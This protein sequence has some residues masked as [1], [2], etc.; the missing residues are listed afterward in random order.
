[1]TGSP[2]AMQ[3]R[4]VGVSPPEEQR[5]RAHL[6]RALEQVFPVRFEGREFGAWRELDAV[7]SLE[8]GG[9]EPEL[10]RGLRSFA[11]SWGSV[12][13]D[14][15]GTVGIGSS[16][17]VDARL[18]TRSLCDAR[19][20]ALAGLPPERSTVLAACGDN[21][22]WTRRDAMDRV[23]LA[24]E[25]A[26]GQSIRDALAPGRWLSLL[27]LV[28]YLRDVAGDLAWES[29]PTRA[30]FMI[31]DPNLHWPSYGYVR[32]AELAKHA[33]ADGYHVAVATI[34]LDAWLVHPGVARVFR[35]N[36]RSLSLLVHGNDHVREEL[37]RP[38]SKREALSLL[39][40]AVRR[41]TALQL[42][43]G[44]AIDRLM[45]AP[46]GVCSEEM[47]RT[48]LLVGFEGLCYSWST[49]R[50]SDQPL[51][52]WEPSELRAGLPVFPRFLVTKPRD[53]IVLRSF[54]GQPLILY[55]HHSDLANG[56]DLFG[57]AAAFV[58]REPGVQWGGAERIARSSYLTRRE[59]KALTVRLCAR[60]VELQIPPG[61]E[62]LMVELPS[63]HS[64]PQQ[65]MVTFRTGSST[66]L[67]GFSGLLAGPFP[68]ADAG[69]AE[70]Y[71]THIDAVDPDDIRPP[72][73]RLHPIL[74]RVA[75]ESR[76]RLTPLAKPIR[77][78]EK[79]GPTP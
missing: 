23:A 14:A 64:A 66:T 28:H 29:P 74:R 21:A 69:S 16:P 45:V 54:L 25:L 56:L 17:L 6:F 33:E 70:I 3:R 42:R 55:A 36:R 1:M 31:D 71:L 58:N 7:I 49:P 13:R 15:P 43:A 76:D 39:A 52:G 27:P 32:F 65:E 60:N 72:R 26:P 30:T 51:V 77:H 73:R 44:V 68:V 37:A 12:E 79:R 18:R 53:E 9:A 8:N 4:T 34:P 11:A 2:A 24:P 47:M 61:V 46:H 19:A 59:G 48:M 78:K 50:S 22:L 57:E 20:G 10:P 62:E 63:A 41:V 67:S 5:K 40:Q 75:T 35:E 38:R